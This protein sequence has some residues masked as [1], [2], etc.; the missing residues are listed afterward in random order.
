MRIVIIGAGAIGGITAAYLA[1]AGLDVA[2][3]CR[4]EE[5][6]A[7]IRENGLHIVGKRGE[8]RHRLDAVGDIG[9]LK[10]LYDCCLIATKAY[11]LVSAA[12]RVLPFL[13]KEAL[14]VALQNGICTDLLI[15][16]V[17]KERAAGAIVTWSAT[18]HGD[19][20]MEFTGEG[21]FIL[22]MM[23]GGN[24]ARLLKVQQALSHM[25]PTTLT[26]DYLSQ[27]FAKLIINSGITCGGAMAGETLGRMLLRRDA[28]RLFLAIVREDMKIAEAMGVTVPRFG[29]R[30]DYYNFIAGD[31][32]WDHLRR[33]IVLLVIGF[34]YRRLR[35]S[36]L[37]SL[38]R[39]GKTEVDTLNGWIAQKGLELGVATP[40]NN[41]VARII[42]EIEAGDRP[43]TP[44]NIKDALKA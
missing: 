7:A 31:A 41:A 33:H 1:K 20:E 32:I 38:L 3:V 23:R 11:D 44:Q 30:L 26:Q 8:Q 5:A 40:V 27:M 16:A 18:M 12:E 15:N 21:G 42:R 17:G 10:G 39:G 13:T 14:I 19:A 25:A 9:A 36:S 6:A 29:G 28:R 22:G 37:T 35:S 43:I 24:D 34:Q 2:L 4:R